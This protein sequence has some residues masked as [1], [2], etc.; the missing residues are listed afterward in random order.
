MPKQLLFPSKPNKGWLYLLGWFLAAILVMVSIFYGGRTILAIEHVPVRLVVYGFSTQELAFTQGIF[1]AFESKWEAE[2]GRDLIIDGL[3]G[4]S[5]T[6]AGQINLGA[7]ADVAIFSNE[8]HVSLLKFGQQIQMETQPVVISSTPIIIVTRPGN[9]KGIRGFADLEQPGLLLFHADPR[10]SGV[11]EW[12]ILAEYGSALQDIGCPLIAEQQTINIWRNVRLMVPSAQTAMSQ[13]EMGVGDALV[14]NE[15]DARM[16]LARGAALEI[17]IPTN[18]IVAQHVAVIVDENVTPEQR[19][20]AEE[21]IQFILSDSGQQ[22]LKRYYH[23]SFDL[24]DNGFPK[25]NHSFTVEDLGGWSHAHEK[26]I[27]TLWQ[28]DIEPY[29]ILEPNSVVPSPGE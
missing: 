15:Q 25:L 20:V 5:G 2:T 4:S 28:E 9:P 18:T 11:G 12:T 6:L 29:L 27:S 17:V 10:T 23:R 24:E 22:I 26:L 14:T 13:F 1:P 3:F 19:L 8:R 16:A 21:F 7:P